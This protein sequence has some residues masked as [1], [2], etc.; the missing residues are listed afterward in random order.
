MLG[1]RT[2]GYLRC[3]RLGVNIPNFGDLPEVLSV[4]TM[5]REAEI[6]GADSVLLADHILLVDEPMTGY[7][8]T[9]DGVF[10]EA[11]TFPFY[12]ALASSA[13]VAAVTKHCRIGIG[14]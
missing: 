1:V 7:P 13:F 2:H 5:A 11:G 4:G 3:M 10:P 9:P 8:Y 6:A 12:D 14:V